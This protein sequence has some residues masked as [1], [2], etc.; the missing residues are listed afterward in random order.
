LLPPIPQKLRK[1][2]D[3]TVGEH[4]WLDG[5]DGCYYIW[6]Y[7]ARK[8]YDFSPANQLVFNLKI[9]PSAVNHVPAGRTGRHMLYAYSI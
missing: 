2:D 4:F 9:K 1:I 6:E 5:T 3:S 8:R 7:A